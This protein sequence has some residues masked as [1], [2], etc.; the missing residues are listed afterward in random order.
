MGG[1]SARFKVWSHRLSVCS[2]AGN[3]GNDGRRPNPGRVALSTEE[4]M[5][6]FLRNLLGFMTVLGLGGLAW[7]AGPAPVADPVR[8]VAF[9]FDDL[10]AARPRGLENTQALTTAL[11]GRIAAEGI[12]AVGFVNEGKLADLGLDAAAG[13]ALLEPWLAAGLE[14]GNHTRSHR[15]FWKTPLDSM[16]LDVL[17]GERI[18]RGLCQR[19]G[20]P[21]HWF[22][23]PY[24]NTGPDSASK[25]AF[26]GFLAEHGFRVAPVT[27][28]NDEYVHARAYDLARERRDSAAMDS[29]AADYLRYMEGVVVHFEEQARRT[30]GREPAQVLLLHANW[31]N[32]ERLGPL[33]G[34]FR[35][36][37]YGIIGLDEALKDSA[38]A[39]P[40]TY[41]GKRGMSW[42][43]RWALSRGQEPG[44]MPEAPDW[45]RA[46]AGL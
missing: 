16:Q 46:A 39:L 19:H 4:E 14:L 20:R 32:A 30:L 3:V 1:V 26:E 12:P 9:T 2:G 38:Y 7:S 13:A 40:D 29:I 31:L 6:G 28:D 17:A 25:A 24:L 35:R 15:W 45:V 43:E 33:A 41:I 36:R 11:V 27:L 37:G 42:L 22:R 5:G 18:L 10:P 8:Q 23:H 44:E 34:M 21:L